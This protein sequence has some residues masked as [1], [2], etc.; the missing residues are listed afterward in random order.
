MGSSTDLVP[1]LRVESGTKEQ[2]AMIIMKDGSFRLIL[3][4]RAI[5]F[6]MKDEF[7]KDSI[8]E[9]WGVMLNALPPDFP[10]QIVCYSKKLDAE[11]YF[12]QF[13]QQLNNQNVERYIKE[14]ILDHKRHF[15]RQI[16]SQRLLQREFYI[17]VPFKGVPDPVGERMTDNIP[18]A[19]LFK[20]LF[21]NAERRAIIEPDE[22]EVG[23]ARQQLDMRAYQIQRGLEAMG[24]SAERLGEGEIVQLFYELFHP[25]LSERQKAQRTTYR[26]MPAAMPSASNRRRALPPGPS[27]GFA[28]N[29]SQSNM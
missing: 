19:G 21:H 29:S 17:V 28:Q 25:G 13:D 12:R 11:A 27:P 18:A 16:L 7:E 1:F 23:I 6:D 9:S 22:L 4:A 10:L 5:N 15:S 3:K 20:A 8:L 14:L 26:I 2:G 24:L